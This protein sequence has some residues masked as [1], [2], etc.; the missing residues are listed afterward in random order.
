MENNYLEV[1][2]SV[3]LKKTGEY[4]VPF[5]FFIFAT[6]EQFSICVHVL[7][8]IMLYPHFSLDVNKMSS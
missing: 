5:S 2:G 7:M 3:S 6:R 4:F 1:D 8:Y